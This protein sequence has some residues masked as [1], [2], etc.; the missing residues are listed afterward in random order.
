KEVL[1]DD[2][3]RM[4]RGRRYAVCDKTFRIYGREPYREHF[5]FVEPRVEIPLGEAGPFDCEGTRP[6]HPRETKGEDYHVTT[7]ADACCGPGE[8]C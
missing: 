3:H 7:G 4:V 8:C 1:D 2:G 5:D 6:R